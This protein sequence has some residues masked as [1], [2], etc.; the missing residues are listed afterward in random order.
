MVCMCNKSPPPLLIEDS[1]VL[2][3]GEASRKQAQH[4]A[5]DLFYLTSHAEIFKHIYSTPPT[6]QSTHCEGTERKELGLYDGGDR[7]ME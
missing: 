6:H 2:R 5:E 4:F 3:R 7:L 1:S